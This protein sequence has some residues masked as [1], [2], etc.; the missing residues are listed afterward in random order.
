MDGIERMHKRTNH[1]N[2]VFAA[3]IRGISR[4]AGIRITFGKGWMGNG[5]E[6]HTVDNLMGEPKGIVVIV[7][8]SWPNYVYDCYIEN[9]KD[10]RDRV[11]LGTPDGSDYHFT[12]N[13]YGSR[14]ERVEEMREMFKD[15]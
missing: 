4:T 10:R 7:T 12:H 3:K 6:V 1:K 15:T 13:F 5:A 2:I 11:R 9:Q 14:A 8:I